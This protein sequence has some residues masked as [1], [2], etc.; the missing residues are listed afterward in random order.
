MDSVERVTPM[1]DKPRLLAIFAHPDDESMGTGGM[2]AKYSAEGVETHLVCA[3]RGERGWFGSEESNPGFERLAEIRT[4]E[5]EEAGKVLGLKETHFLNY[6]DGD[7]DQANP[8]EAI[9]KIVTHIRRIKPQVVVTFPHDGNY[10]HPDHIA[11]SQFTNAAVVCAAD[12]KFADPENHVPHRVSKLYYFVD[13]EPFV[14]FITPYLGDIEFPVDDQVRGESAWKEWMITTRVDVS[15]AWKT[16]WEA[17]SC[18]RSQLPSLGPLLE[19]PEDEIRR[20]LTLQGT[21]YRALSLVN[22]GRKIETDLFEGLR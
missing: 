9:G 13:A 17:I 19:L 1:N 22:G 8:M 14:N 18:H 6:I 10:G 16:A 5:L 4:K 12:A 11:I 15:S 2:L 20:L 21:F 7:L 3:T